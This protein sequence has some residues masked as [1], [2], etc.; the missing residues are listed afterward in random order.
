MTV[1]STL[2]GKVTV[3]S[4]TFGKVT[5]IPKISQSELASKGKFAYVGRP[6]AESWGLA[7]WHMSLLP[8]V[9]NLI[10]SSLHPV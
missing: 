1:R 5:A 10:I 6:S 9:K 8:L 2:V 7:R 3:R 4:T